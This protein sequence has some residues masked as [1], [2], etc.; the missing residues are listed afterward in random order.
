MA[1]G[2]RKRRKDA[3]QR[4]LDPS[5]WAYLIFALGGFMGAWVLTNFIEEV[6]AIL[7]R[8]WPQIGRP[9]ALVSNVAGISIAVVAAIIAMRVQRWFRFTTEV[10]VEISQV[11][12]PTRAETRAATVVVI[13]ITL[14]C[15]AILFGID[16]VWSQFT[17]FIYGI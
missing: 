4:E 9:S 12:W 11:V 2:R 17:D 5:R 13:V 7:W 14:I 15:S 10:V 16:Q 3:I 1:E 6:W 8:Y